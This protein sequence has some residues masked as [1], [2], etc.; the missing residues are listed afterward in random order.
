L[1]THCVAQGAIGH[2]LQYR[3]EVDYSDPHRSSRVLVVDDD[4]SVRS[5]LHHQLS[6]EGFDVSVAENGFV[7]LE[8]LLSNIPDVVIT[9]IEMPGLTGSQFVLLMRERPALR[10]V[11]VIF[12]SAN[13]DTYRTSLR[14]VPLGTTEFLRKPLDIDLLVT[15]AASL[16]Q[17]DESAKTLPAMGNTPDRLVSPNLSFAAGA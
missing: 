3:E 11:P 13:I 4:A 8:Q 12:M 17:L 5:A 15:C 16:A 9:D 7:A 1:A 10:H 14:H 2:S 6:V